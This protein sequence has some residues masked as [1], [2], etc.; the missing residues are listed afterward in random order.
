M[1]YKCTLERCLFSAWVESELN[2]NPADYLHCDSE[3]ELEDAIWEE[4][5]DNCDTGNVHWK[6]SDSDIVIPPEF[7]EEWRSLKGLN[8]TKLHE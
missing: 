3:V 7:V 5:Y 2:L 6:D 1:Q 8:N 4:L